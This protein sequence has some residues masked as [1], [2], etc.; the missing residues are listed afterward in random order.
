MTDATFTPLVPPRLGGSTPDA[1]AISAKARVRGYADG[2]AEGR[3]RA[4]EEL[5]RSRAALEARTAQHDAATREALRTALAALDAVRSDLD[6]HLA[7]LVAADAERVEELAIG[8]AE[9]ILDVELSDA[10]RSA[11][12]AVRRA[13]AE[14]PV[15]TWVR[16]H[17]SDRDARTL[18]D[19]A[20]PILTEAEVVVSTDVDAGGAVVELADARVDA[21]IS[22]AVA[23]A[24][25]ALRADD[26]GESA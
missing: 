22:S 19:G 14:A 16:V 1:R 2:F 18:R 17:L 11:A 10:T 24:R 3:R 8:L 6:G 21:R 7:R 26:G 12:H 5:A 20:S 4:E 9:A 13:V 23:R 15:S 25:A